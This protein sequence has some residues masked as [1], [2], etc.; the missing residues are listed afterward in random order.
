VISLIRSL[1]LFVHMNDSCYKILRCVTEFETVHS[2][3]SWKVVQCWDSAA[4]LQLIL[5]PHGK[6]FSQIKRWDSKIS[7]GIYFI[8]FSWYWRVIPY[9]SCCYVPL[10]LLHHRLRATQSSFH[11]SWLSAV[12]FTI[13]QTNMKV[14]LLVIRKLKPNLIAVTV[15]QFMLITL[16]WMKWLWVK[17]TLKE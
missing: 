4:L 10:P 8:M 2:L 15:V 9:N 13:Y 11:S 12:K 14:K 6:L 3:F 5:G 17:F 7:T 1:V 16:H